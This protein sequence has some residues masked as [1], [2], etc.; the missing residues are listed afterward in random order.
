[1]TQAALGKAYGENQSFVSRV[2]RLQRRIDVWEFVRFCAVLKI[3][4]DDII[5]PL[6]ERE[7]KAKRQ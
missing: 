3:N 7:A 4:P 6:Y 5:G 2:E 1:M